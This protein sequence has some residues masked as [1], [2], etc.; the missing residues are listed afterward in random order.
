MK[1][2]P[3]SNVTKF[4]IEWSG[5]CLH[6]L[7]LFLNAISTFISESKVFRAYLIPVQ[8]TTLLPGALNPTLTIGK[9]REHI[10]VIIAEN[11]VI[12]ETI[13]RKFMKN[14]LI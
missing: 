3:F 13:V 9:E 2:K 11:Q 7:I 12:L 8:N 1:Q 10:G 14:Q 4:E 5:C 6:S